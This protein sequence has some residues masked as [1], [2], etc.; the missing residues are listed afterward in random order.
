VEEAVVVVVGE[1]GAEAMERGKDPEEFAFSR[2][3][4]DY[5][6]EHVDMKV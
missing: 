4:Q 1:A 2:D 5:Q 6:A 3:T